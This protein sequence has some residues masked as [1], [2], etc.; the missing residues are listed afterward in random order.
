MP[1]PTHFLIEAG[2][3]LAER[4]EVVSFVGQGGFGQVYK[5]RQ[6][7]TELEVAIKLV[8]GSRDPM[9]FD[10]RVEKS[11]GVVVWRTPPAQ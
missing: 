1:E 3:I 4:Y 5:A 10:G 11:T 2:A 9:R 6:L 8:D 7:A